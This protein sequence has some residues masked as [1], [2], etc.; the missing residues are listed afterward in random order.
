MRS[1]YVLAMVTELNRHDRVPVISAFLAPL[2]GLPLLGP[3]VIH[4]SLAE[5]S[6]ARPHVARA[7]DLHLGMGVGGVALLIP[8]TFLFGY[9]IAEIIAGVFLVVAMFA[10]FVLLVGV[11]RG[12]RW[13]A[14]WEPAALGRR[15]FYRQEPFIR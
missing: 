13:S 6:A 2:V 12:A 1:R 14:P 10:S 8:G 15:T 5:D 3:W 4:A 11:L 9:A 7:F